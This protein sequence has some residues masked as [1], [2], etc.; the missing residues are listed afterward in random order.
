MKQKRNARV[1][2]RCIQAVSLV[3]FLAL[4]ALTAWP[5]IAWLPQDLY[6]RLDPL[7]ALLVPVA[8]REWIGP[9]WP[10]ILVI[11][12]SCVFG[13]IFC[14]YICP[15]GI[16][17]DLARWWVRLVKPGAETARGAPMPAPWRRVKFLVLTAMAAAAVFGVNLV[18]WGSPIALITRFY[19]LVAHPFLLFAGSAFLKAGQPVFTALDLS[20]L[21]YA[22]LAPRRFDT[23]WFVLLFFAVLFVLERVRPRF[24][25]RYLC[26]AGAILA[27]AA[28]RPL[29]RR[30]VTR[31][32]GCGRCVRECP[33][34]AIEPGGRE[35]RHA[36]C[37]TC[38][39]CVDVCPVNGV[40]FTMRPVAVKRD[41]VEG[42]GA[43]G[44]DAGH[45][46]SRRAFLGAAG[47]GIVLSGLHHTQAYGLPAVM[48]PTGDTLVRPPGALPHPAFLERCIR[49]GLC[50]KACPTNALQPVWF[51]SGTEGMFSPQVAPRGGPCEPDCA[52]CGAVCPTRA[53]LPLPLAEKH[54]AKIGTAVVRRQRCLAWAEGRRCMVCQEVCPYGSVR[55]T[56]VEG[57]AVPVPVVD[58]K[59]CFGC[60]YCEYHCPTGAPSIVVEPLHALRLADGRYEAAARSLGYVLEPGAHGEAYA[61]EPAEAPD[62]G[63]P[64]GFGP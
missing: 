7:V 26:P 19:A 24:W 9:L 22:S 49:C 34:R 5:L 48:R 11:A 35:T 40:T 59:R 63:L 42:E 16:T 30:K 55:I 23:V 36:E 47:T 6:L 52:A 37:I 38:R 4:L 44:K 58:P 56:Q 25:C 14:G 60:G 50:M 3:L 21:T 20:S 28:F 39:S 57:Q 51:E 13:R 31:C 61:P 43:P 17:L 33:T 18:F 15:M 64:P 53:I 2:Q 62:G 46:P 10:G 1:L 32:T 8:A 41:G 29:W 27:L 12:A 45:L 54:R